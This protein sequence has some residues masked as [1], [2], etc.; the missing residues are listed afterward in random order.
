MVFNKKGAMFG[1]D[2]R[3]ALA[4]FGALS[5]ISG[6]A[7]YS[8]I[9]DARVTAIVTDLDELGKATTQ[10]LLDT[11]AYP[12]VLNGSTAHGIMKTESLITTAGTGWNGPYISYADLGTATDGSLKHTGGKAIL[13]S[14]MKAGNWDDV[15][16]DGPADG[17]SR[18]NK[19]DNCAVFACL[20]GQSDDIQ[21]A[22]DLKVDGGTSNTANSGKVR[23]LTSGYVC[24]NVMTFDS[25]NSPYADPV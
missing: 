6:A 21:K 2:A 19:N 14:A 4:I 23:Y 12:A 15:E 20:A 16:D 17:D 3:I 9:Q 1:L 22:I 11:G 25:A 24:M 18:C 8:A 10:F 5:V 7:L 13:V